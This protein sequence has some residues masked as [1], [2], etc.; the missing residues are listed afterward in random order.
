MGL[1][2]NLNLASVALNTLLLAA[3]LILYLRIWREVPTG[4]TLG[5]AFFAAVLLFQNA[6]QLYFF[7]TMMDYYVG[8]VQTLVLVQNLLATLALVVLVAVTW[9]PDAAKRTAPTEGPA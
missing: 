7:A 8:A 1:V 3:L 9:S 6:V 2:M 5:L 4:F